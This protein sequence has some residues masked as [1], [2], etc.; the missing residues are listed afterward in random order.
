M[1]TAEVQKRLGGDV[2]FRRSEYVGPQVGNR[3]GVRRSGGVCHG[4]GA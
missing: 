1:M 3:R 2:E 4:G